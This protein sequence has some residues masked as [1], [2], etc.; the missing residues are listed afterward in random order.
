MSNNTHD[1]AT[2]TQ[3]SDSS[4]DGATTQL[5]QLS[6]NSATRT[7]L[8]G[9]DDNETESDTEIELDKI[10]QSVGQPRASD[11]YSD[12]TVRRPVA[13]SPLLSPVPEEAEIDENLPDIYTD[14]TYRKRGHRFGDG[15]RIADI[16]RRNR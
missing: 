11:V 3:D 16:G 7:P 6:V 10:L 5:P 14:I 13:V 1:A 9:N 12:K 4:P 15:R 8:T 2:M